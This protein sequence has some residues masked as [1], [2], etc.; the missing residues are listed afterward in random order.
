M[1]E[2]QLALKEKAEAERLKKIARAKQKRLTGVE[3]TEDVGSDGEAMGPAEEEA[4]RQRL[5]EKIAA[6]RASQEK[7][8]DID[9]DE[10]PEREKESAQKEASDA[11]QAPPAETKEEDKVPDVVAR[12]ACG[13]KRKDRSQLQLI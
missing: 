9:D 7:E 6:R 2:R 13:A 5:A 3:P 12:L 4:R 11:A 8:K 10:A 1:G